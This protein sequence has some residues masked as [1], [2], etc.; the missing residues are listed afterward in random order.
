MEERLRCELIQVLDG[1]SDF[2]AI[3]SLVDYRYLY[4]TESYAD[5]LGCG[6]N[7]VAGSSDECFFGKE[8]A[9]QVRLRDVAIQQSSNIQ[10]VVAYPLPEIDAS[11]YGQTV[12]FYWA[13]AH[14][15]IIIALPENHVFFKQDVSARDGEL[16]K[17]LSAC[18]H[19]L[20][21][22]LRAVRGFS[23]ILIKQK[24]ADE[25]YSDIS[26]LTRINNAALTMTKQL[27]SLAEVKRAITYSER[28]ARQNLSAIVA[29]L[30]AEY[31]QKYPQ[32]TFSFDVQ[33]HCFAFMSHQDAKRVLTEVIDNAV[34]FTHT[35]QTSE[36]SFFF[37]QGN[38]EHAVFAV[39][40]NGVG[41]EQ[42]IKARLFEPFGV[43]HKAED[44]GG[45]G[46]G[47]YVAYLLLSRYGG[48]IWAESDDGVGTVVFFEIAGF[49]GVKGGA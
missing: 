16:I 34:K 26:Y 24:T 43:L 1:I 12:A 44:G 28:A 48:R 4:A 38:E 45:S 2:Y 19:D 31:Q 15:L 9:R 14:V 36:I 21:A 17:L 40:D 20:S 10:H 29:Q 46:M 30:F 37:S 22:P 32:R 41:F 23:D 47:L 35:C 39:R 6:R 33:D 42:D 7:E 3:K 49:Q 25:H 5:A 27:E 11:G 18:Y 8:H 13:S